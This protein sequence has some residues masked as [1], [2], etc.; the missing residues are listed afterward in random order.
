MPFTLNECEQLLQSNGIKMT[1][2]QVVECYM[3]FGGIPYYLNY[4]NPSYSLAQNVDMLFFKENAPLK[5]EFTQLF[6]ALFKNNGNYTDIVRAMY[7][8]QAGL[9]RAELAASGKTVQ[10]KELTRCLE[11][12]E[13]CGF[14]RKAYSR[15]L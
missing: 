4:L 9:T 12:M 11:D 1:R 5:F 10:G 13:Q 15:D 14:I 6:K 3:I 8:K 2:H 7:K